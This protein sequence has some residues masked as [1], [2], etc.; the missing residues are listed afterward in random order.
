MAHIWLRLRSYRRGAFPFVRARFHASVDGAPPVVLPGRQTL[1]PVAP[2]RRHLRV[3][4]RRPHLLGP[5][6][7]FDTL[8]RDVCVGDAWIDVPMAAT[9][10]VEYRV[11]FHRGMAADLRV[12][13]VYDASAWPAGPA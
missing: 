2:G 3:W 9:V 13:H 1:L 11:G 4:C 6:G 12:A 7:W 5:T 8:D 10:E